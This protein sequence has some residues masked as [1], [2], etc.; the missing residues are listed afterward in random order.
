MNSV[1]AAC[2]ILPSSTEYKVSEEQNQEKSCPR[3]GLGG[4]TSGLCSSVLY[5]S[6]KPR[7]ALYTMFLPRN[8]KK[9]V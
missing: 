8:R 5:I 7:D 3:A 4:T 9:G 1:G 6:R 2:H